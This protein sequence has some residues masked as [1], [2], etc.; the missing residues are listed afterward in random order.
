MHRHIIS[1]NWRLGFTLAVVAMLFWAT[2]PIALKLALNILDAWTLTWFRFLIAALVTASWVIFRH[3]LKEFRRLKSG[4]WLLLLVAA[5]MLIANYILYLLGLER[6][7]PAAVQILIQLAPLLMAVGGL[8]V[9]GE[10]YSRVQWSGFILLLLGLGLF[11]HDQLKSVAGQLDRYVAG[12]LIIILAA[13]VWAIYALAQKQLLRDI[14]SQSIMGFIY[15]FASLSLL[16]AAEISDIGL[17]AGWQW[18][19]I[20]YC[21]FNTIAAYGAFAEALNHWETSRVG[22]ILSV[23]PLGTLLFALAMNHYWPA[24]LEPE[25]I[26]LIGWTGALLVVAG[27]MM[28]S[29]G[30][31]RNSLA[32]S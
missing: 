16:P 28:T 1:G 22:T 23:T 21:A 29:L 19:I 15:L 2:L 4:S 32:A 17:I 14:H 6:T 18:L 31:R 13:V 8:L 26:N 24:A 7:T 5:V 25:N 27:S 11:F 3:G 9:F 12:I 20:A 30:G 10:R